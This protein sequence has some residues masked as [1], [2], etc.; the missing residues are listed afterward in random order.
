MS[1]TPSGAKVLDFGVAKRFLTRTT[2]VPI[3]T[4]ALTDAQTNLLF[5]TPSYMSPEQAFGK[6]LD[7]RSDLF[8]F[9]ALLYEMTT[10]Q[11]AFHGDTAV[12]TLASVLTKE[13]KPARQ[14]NPA[15]PRELDD[16]IRRCLQKNRD[17][18]FA[19]A[20]QALLVL[21]GIRDSAARHMR[22]RMLIVSFITLFALL[23]GFF[24]WRNNLRRSDIPKLTLRRLT[25]GD[26][27]SSVS[28][29]PDGKRVVYSSDRSGSLH[30]WLQE[31]AGG[32]PVRL[33][34]DSSA[35]TDPVFSPDGNVI[36]FRSDQDGGGVYVI[37]AAGG[38]KH[39]I[40]P[41]GRNP[42]YSPDGKW[43]TYW[44]GLPSEGDVVRAGSA[45]SFVVPAGG[46]ASRQI[47]RI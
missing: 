34:T 23:C 18:R 41:G 40:A 37:S 39:L 5:G 27:A 16:F 6:A 45:R 3:Q 44:E 30:L 12:S 10:R 13:P 19:D 36:A 1:C 33:T 42:S 31:L 11:R 22:R 28:L 4:L 43:I 24:W 21:E 15:A 2:Q 8:S 38:N 35:D 7:A 32:E 14:L 47:A 17:R 25:G 46:G 20:R 29:S 26:V 9:G